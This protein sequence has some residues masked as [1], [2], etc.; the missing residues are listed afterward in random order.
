LFQDKKEELKKA[1]R[2]KKEAEFSL[3]KLRLYKLLE[4]IKKE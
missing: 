1:V 3:E 4:N 2:R